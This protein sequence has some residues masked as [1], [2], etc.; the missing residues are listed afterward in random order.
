MLGSL[1]Q[2]DGPQRCPY[3]PALSPAARLLAGEGSYSHPRKQQIKPTAHKGWSGLGLSLS[4]PKVTDTPLPSL[5]REEGIE[6]CE[7]KGPGLL[8]KWTNPGAEQETQR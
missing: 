2:L 5:G 1:L 3:C 8:G 7:D 4:D 6:H